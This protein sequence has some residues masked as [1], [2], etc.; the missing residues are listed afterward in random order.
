MSTQLIKSTVASICPELS[1]CI[2]EAVR[3]R[4]DSLTKPRGS[5]GRLESEVL[6]LAQ[7]QDTAMPHIERPH[8]YVFCGDHGI[9]AENVSPYPSTV[10]RE[11]VHNFLRG[12]AAI[13]VLCRNL[14]IENIV[15]DAGVCG[16]KIPGVIDCRVAEGTRNFLREPAM[17]EA[18]AAQSVEAGISLACQAAEQS[19]IAGIGEMGIGNSTAASALLCA[20]TG[21]APEEAVGRGAGLDEAGLQ[22]KRSVVVSALAYHHQRMEEGN[23]L[24]ILAAFGG[25]EI[26]MMGGFLLGAAAHRLPVVVDGFISGAAFLA[27]R[28]FYPEIGKHVFFAHH[29]AEL[30]HKPLLHAAAALPLLDLSMCLG[31]GTGAA[32]AMALLRAGVQLY[33]EMATFSEAAI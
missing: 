17:S 13:S 32:L 26:A 31:E 1:P 3:Q 25:F 19:D 6:R 29:S 14:G 20:F 12:G 4:S 22:H 27:A 21:V 33:R 8:I 2:A 10:T 28:A 11:M 7:I 23:P 18:Q 24:K 16:P 9:T 5:L 30:G 15:V